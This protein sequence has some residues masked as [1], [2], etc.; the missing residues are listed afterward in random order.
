MANTGLYI[1]Y[2]RAAED[3]VESG[4]FSESSGLILDARRMEP[5]EAA[6]LSAAVTV[7]RAQDPQNHPAW[8]EFEAVT[9]CC[10]RG[11]EIISRMRDRWP[12][13]HWLPRLDIHQPEVR[14]HFNAEALGEGFKFYIPD[15]GAIQAYRCA[16]DESPLQRQMDRAAALGFETLWLHAT[17]AEQ[18]GKGFDLDLLERASSGF[19]GELWLSGGAVTEQHLVNVT[20][21]GGAAAVVVCDSVARQCGCDRLQLALADGEERGAPVSFVSRQDAAAAEMV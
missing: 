13:L 6:E 12:D 16:L 11:L 19:D 4:L 15:T 7:I 5:D 1:S 14:Y 10:D 17:H 8:L 3:A 18:A 20:R 21:Q 2:E 9:W